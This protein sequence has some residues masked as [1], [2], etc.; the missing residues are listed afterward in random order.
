MELTLVSEFLLVLEL[1]KEKNWTIRPDCRDGD[2]IACRKNCSI[3][4][5]V[6]GQQ[7]WVSPWW[8]FE[9]HISLVHWREIRGTK[10]K[11]ETNRS[12]KGREYQIGHGKWW[13]Q[14]IE[15]I[16]EKP[17]WNAAQVCNGLHY[18]CWSR[19]YNPKYKSCHRLILWQKWL[20]HRTY[21]IYTSK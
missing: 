7:L 3:G 17:H 9:F 21:Y 20:Q 14:I 10:L 8:N 18:I 16:Q 11:I 1:S 15:H 19:T 6:A 5:D 4:Y 12:L 2:K 13:W